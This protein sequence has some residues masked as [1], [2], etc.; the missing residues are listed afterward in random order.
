MEKL[1]KCAEGLKRHNFPVTIVEN[2]KLAT[3]LVS[4]M[5]QDKENVG[6]GGSMTLT[7]CGIL[8]MLEKRDV[9]YLPHRIYENPEDAQAEAI[10]AFTSDI[11]LCSAN[12]ITLDGEIV[13]VDG[14]GN[15]V[16]NI[17][18]GPKRVLLVCGKNKLVK[19]V[20]SAY[21]RIARVAAPRNNQR[22]H[23]LNP[24]TQKGTC[25]QCF[26]DTRICNTYVTLA[27]Q[28]TKRIHVILIDEEVGY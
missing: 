22:L 1:K 23:T 19:D 25:V 12:A 27:H 16:A 5:I 8:Q 9:C 6:V 17:I 3:K 24:C 4:D 21:Q 15:R 18:Y 13:C 10:H 20:E 28:I 7:E 11:Y 26:A 14:I 2:K